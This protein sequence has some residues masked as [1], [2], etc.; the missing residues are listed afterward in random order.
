VP[1]EKQS[2]VTLDVEGVLIPEIWIAV[3]EVTGIDA[4]KRTTREE[5]DYD[6]LMKGRLQLLA[7]H[8]LGMDRIQ[9]VIADLRPLDGAREFLDELRRNTQVVLLSD[10]FRQ[11]GTPM[12][13][14]LGYP[15]LL[16]H[17]LVVADDVIVDY[18][19]RMPD[20]KRCAVRSFQE[21]NYA[22]AA[23]GDS[24]ND[25]TMLGQAD[26]GYLF[27]AP[28]NVIDEFPQFPALESYDSLLA[29]LLER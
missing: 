22:V 24:Y 4:L 13:A 26:R 8:G 25:T 12:M 28:Q 18:R 5:P 14:H 11:F 17:D 7:E 19:L 27:N 16:C 23:A 9:Q 2:L 10:T 1:L 15:T 20:Q 6:V 29:A 3:A 21:L